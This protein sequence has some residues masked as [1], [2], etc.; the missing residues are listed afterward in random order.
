[1]KRL[2]STHDHGWTP[3]ILRKQERKIKNVSLCQ[4]VMAV[5]LVMEKG[6]PRQRNRGYAQSVPPKRGIYVFLFKE[7]GLDLLLD[8]KSPPGREP[9]LTPE[10]QQEG[11]IVSFDLSAPYSSQLNPIE[12]L[13]KWLKDAVIAN[14]FWILTGPLPGLWTTFANARKKCFNVWGVLR[15]VEVNFLRCIYV[16]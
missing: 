3:R 8:R 15:D 4:R 7:G 2:K 1:M 13:W 9:F 5:R 10:Q 14:L 12:R 16:C 11:G 6:I